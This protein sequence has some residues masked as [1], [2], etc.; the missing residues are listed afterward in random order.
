MNRGIELTE[1]LRLQM[2]VQKRLHEQLE[3]EKNKYPDMR[4]ISLYQS[5]FA[6]NESSELFY[7][8]W[9]FHCKGIFL[10]RDKLF[11]ACLE[12]S[13]KDLFCQLQ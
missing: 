8:S 13:C 1:A 11:D 10:E 7:W 6:E 5:R 4:F 3:V 12:N 2:D 9:F